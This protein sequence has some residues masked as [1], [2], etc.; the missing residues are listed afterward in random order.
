MAV[1]ISEESN[2]II[3]MEPYDGTTSNIYIFK[4]WADN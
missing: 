2:A 1:K 4:I 3:W